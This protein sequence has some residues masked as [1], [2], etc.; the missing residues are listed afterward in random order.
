MYYEEKEVIN[1]NKNFNLC[2]LGEYSDNVKGLSNNSASPTD[3]WI[4]TFKNNITFEDIPIKRAF[5]KIFIDTT[6]SVTKTPS[7]LALNYELS[8]YN[9]IINKLVLYN[10]CPNFFLSKSPSNPQT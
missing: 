2:N 6:L 4:I 5:L 7:K 8:I 1:L 9:T 10:I 3:T